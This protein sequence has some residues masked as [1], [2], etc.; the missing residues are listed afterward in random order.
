VTDSVP[1]A[2]FASRGL[3]AILALV[4]LGAGVLWGVHH[5]A[6]LM[7]AFTGRGNPL[8]FTWSVGFLLLWWIGLSWLERP[9]TTTPRQQRRVDQLFVT[10]QVPVWNEDPRLLRACLAS[11]FQ[12]TRLPDRI[13]VVDDGSADDLSD[14]RHR[15]LRTAE[16]LGIQAS[17]VRTPNRGKR[18]AQM[19]AL[20]TDDG[21]IFVTLDSDSVLDRHAL[22]EG[23]KPF[24][25]PKVQ[26]V[27]G[28]VAVWNNRAN[29]LTRLTCMLYTP[30][31]RGFRSAQSILG[32]VMVN[33]GTLAFYRGDVI[34]RYAG[35]YE[36]ETFFGRPVQMNDDS[37][38]TFYALLA[39]KTVHQPTSVAY[40]AVPERLGHYLR[41]QLRWM[42]GTF[43]RIWWW[44]RYMPL[45]DLTFWMAL[46]E[47]FAIALSGIIIVTLAASPPEVRGPVGQLLFTAL[48]V[49]IGVNWML[50]LRYLVVRRTDETLLFQLSLVAAAPIAGL[51][52]VVILRPLI[53]YAMATCWKTNWGTR[54]QV[55][56]AGAAPVH[57]RRHRWRADP[58]TA[59]AITGVSG[60]L[61]VALHQL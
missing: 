40:T 44:F 28:M 10:V 27:A 43:V 53:F 48:A 39:G 56:V 23:L 6:S 51:W 42:R 1:E 22:E 4:P 38:L 35:S 55:E 47:V 15:F 14:E 59:A 32:R 52:R 19:E 5:A 18:Y 2:T 3:V 13:A 21:D 49:D 24:A 9:A 16:N 20:A 41:Q 26:S 7:L 31:T 11:L 50:G 57:L 58:W 29:L 34:R 60:C 36:R 17:W 61:A 25:D 30:F 8:A 12:Q 37:M 33:S 46:S 45:G 54:Q